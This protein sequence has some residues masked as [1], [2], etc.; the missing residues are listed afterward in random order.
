[1]GPDVRFEGKRFPVWLDYKSIKIDGKEI[2]SSP[3]AVWHNKPWRYEMP[4]RDEQEVWVEY[5]Q[6]PHPYSRE[7]LKETILKLNPTSEAIQK[8]I[9]AL[10]DKIYKAISHAK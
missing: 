2:L 8:N 4:V 6:Q 9:N 10:T 7:E 5:E 1:M 3:I